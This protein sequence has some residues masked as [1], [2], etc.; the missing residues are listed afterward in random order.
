M[1][2]RAERPKLDL[3]NLYRP[4]LQWDVSAIDEQQPPVPDN[5]VRPM[6]SY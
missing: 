3:N 1:Q 5:P 2:R 4:I 6:L